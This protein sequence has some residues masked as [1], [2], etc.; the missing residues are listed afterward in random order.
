[1][2]KYCANSNSILALETYTFIVGTA[3][4]LLVINR[5]WIDYGD[6]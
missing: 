2:Q 6:V 5:S 3:Q 4:L 1:M